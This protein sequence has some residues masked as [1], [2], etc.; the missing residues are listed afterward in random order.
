VGFV[1]MLSGCISGNSVKNKSHSSIQPVFPQ[2]QAMSHA[3][4]SPDATM[5]IAKNHKKD[6]LLLDRQKDAFKFLAKE[7]VYE[8]NYGFTPDQ[9]YIFFIRTDFTERIRKN[10]LVLHDLSRDKQIVISKNKRRLKILGSSQD[11]HSSN[12]IFKEN[13][14]VRAYDLQGEKFTGIPSHF[15]TSYASQNLEICVFSAGKEK[16]IQPLGEG[17]YLWVSLSPNKKRILFTYAGKGSYSCDL[18]GENIIPYEDIRAPRWSSDG[19]YV[20]GM[21]DKDNGVQYTASDIIMI[22]ADGTKRR[23]LTVDSELI[24]LY[25]ELSSKQ[26]EILFQDELGKLYVMKID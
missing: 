9:K 14:S 24:A 22:L 13:D 16:I 15:I 3:V 5:I 26:D 1:V 25:P 2:N 19:N 10:E 20:I 17:N 21:Q 8:E 23:N 12:I 11:G 7:S 6:L 4:F 18:K